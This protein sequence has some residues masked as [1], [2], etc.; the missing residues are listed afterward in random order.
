MKTL[1]LL[2]LALFS[3][4]AFAEGDGDHEKGP[5]REDVKK[6]CAGIE[7]GGGAILKCM[8][9]HEGQVSAGC[10]AHLEQKKGELKE[11][12]GQARE[13]CKEDKEKFCKDVKPGGGAIIKCMKSHEAELS[14]GCKATMGKGPGGRRKK[15]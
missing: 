10:K 5:C 2:S 14:A 12:F 9:E 4:P 8:K 15:D 11:K 1:I 3:L 6:L 7:P 13:A